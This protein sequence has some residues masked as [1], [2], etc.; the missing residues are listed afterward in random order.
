MATINE[1]TEASMG[2]RPVSVFR[3]MMLPIHDEAKR[4]E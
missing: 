1:C 2:S 3:E 4:A